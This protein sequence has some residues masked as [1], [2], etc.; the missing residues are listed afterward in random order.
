MFVI[1]SVGAS[2][3][4]GTMHYIAN[5]PSELTNGQVGEIGNSVH[6]SKTIV[7]V[8]VVPLLRLDVSRL[9]S[10]GLDIANRFKTTQHERNQMI[11]LVA[12]ENHTSVL[13]RD[14][15]FIKVM[16]VPSQV[17]IVLWLARLSFS[18]RRSWRFKSAYAVGLELPGR[19]L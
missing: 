11:N 13:Y 16:L 14:E 3:Q 8:S 10:F 19:K 5:F 4:I 2:Q 6:V 18:F 9:L 1:V 15:G 17:M 7:S 12:H